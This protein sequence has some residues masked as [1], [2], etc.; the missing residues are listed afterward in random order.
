MEI[1]DKIIHLLKEKDSFCCEIFPGKIPSYFLNDNWVDLDSSE[2]ISEQSF[3]NILTYFFPEDSS[4]E[5]DQKQ[6][7][8]V[9]KTLQSQN[10]CYVIKAKNPELHLKIYFDENGKKFFDK[11]WQ[12]IN[13]KNELSEEEPTTNTE[14][15]SKLSAFDIF[16]E[17]NLS[18]EEIKKNKP[19]TSEHIP[20]EGSEKNE[21]LKIEL[22]S[23]STDSNKDSSQDNSNSL[24]NIEDIFKEDDFVESDDKSNVS[25]EEKE[26]N[27]DI[28]TADSIEIHMNQEELSQRDSPETL[29]P[30]IKED[31]ENEEHDF[32]KD[33]HI[34]VKENDQ[35]HDK[36]LSLD[37]SSDGGDE[38]PGGEE[39]DINLD[40]PLEED[41][42]LEE[43]DINL[44]EDLKEDHNIEEHD[45]NLDVPLKEDDSLEEHDINLDE[46]LEEDDS[47]EEQ[48]INLDEGLEG[49]HSLEENDINL[50][51][52]HTLEENDIDLDEDLEEDHTLEENDINLDEG[53]S[54][55][56]EITFDFDAE[57]DTSSK[58]DLEKEE[59][60]DKKE[61]DKEENKLF[62]NENK[63]L[64]QGSLDKDEL[65]N[66]K[67]EKY[68]YRE[69]DSFSENFRKN[70]LS[71][72]ASK[73]ISINTQGDSD[74]DKLLID[75]KE[76]K[77]FSLHI[78]EGESIKMKRLK[79]PQNID[80]KYPMDIRE[81]RKLLFKSMNSFERKSL[82]DNISHEIVYQV[83]GVGCFR[84]LFFMDFSGPSIIINDISEIGVDKSHDL[85]SELNIIS[86]KRLGFL[87]FCGER[88]ISKQ[89]ALTSYFQKSSAKE[90]KRVLFISTGIEFVFT[91]E[92]T[93]MSH[94]LIQKDEEF[95]ESFFATVEKLNPD[96]IVIDDL[97][98]ISVQSHFIKLLRQ[99]YL[100]IS[101]I[102]SKSIYSAIEKLNMILSVNENEEKLS[103]VFSRLKGVVFSKIFVSNEGDLCP[104]SEVMM[105]NEK[106]TQYIIEGDTD[107]LKNY[108]LK[109]QPGVN[110]TLND[111]LLKLVQKKKISIDEASALT[112][113]Y[114]QLESLFEDEKLIKNK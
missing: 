58:N 102:P 76:N 18:E 3:E 74:L 4:Q 55:S 95:S 35:D 77:I 52:D 85:S 47:L 93:I 91:A 16:H 109:S 80:L 97:F 106:I 113:D 78:S 9:K 57:N 63:N 40:I 13:K 94:I 70:Q 42:K 73:I 41:R 79:S 14:D 65:A 111:C 44:D 48:D 110:L 99:G 46:G 92:N 107:G 21:E 12:E 20:S 81:I 114:N 82:L 43:H 29:S 69:S 108:C 87:L 49:D 101:F 66:D 50:D 62:S 31:K 75:M 83:G 15:L 112:D 56:E 5:E 17:D 53:F 30:N 26:K 6:F 71:P 90:T 28:D 38:N 51:E 1:I 24:D 67:E 64:H 98:D 86:Q 84:F 45:I 34:D 88:G 54:E 25:H 39:H 10:E 96:I 103:F 2:A 7:F 23:S 11:K 33:V 104:V 19:E 32:E 22:S 100:V 59:D 68:S 89:V 8:Q 27:P 60:E 36:D 105:P 37:F 72:K 61:G